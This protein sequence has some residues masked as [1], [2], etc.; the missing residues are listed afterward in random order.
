MTRVIDGWARGGLEE[1]SWGWPGLEKSGPCVPQE[2]V[3]VLPS[4][5]TVGFAAAQS[6]LSQGVGAAVRPRG[7]CEG[8]R[9]PAVRPYLLHGM[10]VGWADFVGGCWWW[11]RCRI[12]GS[13]FGASLALKL[14]DAS[15]GCC[16]V[17]CGRPYLTPVP[18][19]TTQ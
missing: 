17:L 13:I 9:R 16:G 15:C 3:L 4:R 5:L 14:G 11:T 12:K 6:S 2:G 1:G 8:S 10:M 7:T 19:P 18:G